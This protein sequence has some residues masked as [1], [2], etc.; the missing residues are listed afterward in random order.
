MDVVWELKNSYFTSVILALFIGGYNQ[1]VGY[2]QKI[3]VQ[4]NFY[5]EAMSS[6]ERFFYP[7]LG[8]DIFLYHIFYNDK[9][10]D[11]T[12]KYIEDADVLLEYSKPDYIDI[13]QDIF[14]ELD[15]IDDARKE[16][17][18]IGMDR[19]NLRD[20]IENARKD[21]RKLNR[22]E[23]L[24]IEKIKIIAQH[25]FYIIAELRRP[26]RWDINN[27][28]KIIKMIN[29]NPENEIENNFYY[30]MHLNGGKILFK[31]DKE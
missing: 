7:V 4:H 3:K 17:R 30:G 23:Q 24:D 8:N 29:E 2:K 13:I 21:L 14:L 1:I 5:V 15:K 31:G 9:C 28:L 11:D 26:W 6:F 10:L 20:Y 22:D 16:D 12:I 25:F 19:D 27:N 18:I